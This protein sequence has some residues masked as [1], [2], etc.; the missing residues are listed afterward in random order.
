MST[1]HPGYGELAARI[2]I[3]N[4]QKLTSESFAETMKMEYEYVS[5]KTGKQ[6]PLVHEEIYNIVMQNKEKLDAAIKHERDF[7]FDYFGFKTL[8]RSYLVRLN[9][10]VVERPQY[11]YMR[12]A[13]GIHKVFIH[14]VQSLIKTRTILMQQ[15]RLTI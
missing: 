9:G 8:E 5:P 11:M 15:L 13:I 10:E 12:V 4:L 1:V 3:S 6:S 2:A 7:A 14:L